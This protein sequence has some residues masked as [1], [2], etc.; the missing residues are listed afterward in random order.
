MDAFAGTGHRSNSPLPNGEPNLFAD[1]QEGEADEFLKGSVAVA[2]EVDPP[3]DR[4]LFVEKDAKRVQC[5]LETISISAIDPAKVMVVQDEAN[6]FILQWC[7]RIDWKTSRAVMFLDPYGMQVEWRTLE[8]I[9]GTKGIDLWILFPL[10]MGVNR[11][12]TKKDIPPQSWCDTLTKIFGTDEWQT[13]FYRTETIQT[14]FGEDTVES[15]RADF[16]SIA[17]YFL[18][19]LKTIFPVVAPKPLI[20]CNSKNNPLFLLCFASG[21]PTKGSLAVKIAQSILKP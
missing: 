21:N 12:L 14:L 11:L 7:A 9:A 17:N 2:L 4:Y 16:K 8:A 18:D 13:H 5:L 10:G 15:K 6:S 3:F 19:R 20:L 1:F